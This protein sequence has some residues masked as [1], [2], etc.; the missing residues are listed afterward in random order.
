MDQSMANKL[1]SMLSG[2]DDKRLSEAMDK[3]SE[4]LK[5]H[6]INEI[7]TAIMNNDMSRIM[8]QQ[9]DVDFS[10]LIDML[11]EQKKLE[12]CKKFESPEVQ[13]ALKSDKSKALEIIKK[14]VFDK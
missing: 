14:V 4:I 10:K 7:K 9:T 6:D 8:G 1:L 13:E 3:A 2:I 11:P 12:L 5:K